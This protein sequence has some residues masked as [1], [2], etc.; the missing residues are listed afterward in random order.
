VVSFPN[1]KINLGLNILQKR[2]DGFHDIETIFY[3]IA[4][5]DA[6]EIISDPSS[7]HD[8]QINVSGVE[9]KTTTAE[10]ICYKAYQLLKKDFPEIPAIKIH[11]HK[12]IPAGSG[13]GGGSADGAFTLLL[14]NKKFNLGL[15]EA[16]LLKYALQLGSDCPFFIKNKPAFAT[17]R[18]EVLKEIELDLSGWKM[19]IINPGIHINTAWAF[20]KITPSKG[21][22]SLMEIVQKPMS[23]WKEELKNDFEDAVFTQYPELKILKDHLYETGAAY[24]SMSGS[25]STIYALFDKNDSPQLDIPSHYFIKHI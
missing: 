9:I 11:L 23:A 8:V 2:T 10:N 16:E 7:S 17:G 21:R 20:S 19:I 13:L 24:A 1:C 14:L 12:T 3:P 22:R 4:F 25:G 5:Q 15:D 18:G 6:V